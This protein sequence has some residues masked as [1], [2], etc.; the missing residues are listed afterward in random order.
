MVMMSG[1]ASSI[2]VGIGLILGGCAGDDPMSM[3]SGETEGTGG[4]TEA[5]T[6]TGSAQESGP[7]SSGGEPTPAATSDSSGEPSD[8]ST[9]P[10]ETTGQACVPGQTMADEVVMIG[11]SYL[12]ITT[13]PAELF[14]HARA[15]GAL[16]EDEVW[17]RYDQGGTQMSNGQIP[18]QFDDALAEDPVISTVVMTGGG[19]DVLL[20]SANG[21]LQNPP[22]DDPDCVA[23]LEAVF[24]AA[25]ALLADMADAGVERV[26]YF[27]YPHL[28]DGGFVQGAKNE[29]LDYAYP[30]VEEICASAP[31][32]CVF[33]DTRPG[34]E[35]HQ[36]EYFIF[37]GVHPNDA[38]SAVIAQAVW[39]AMVDNCIAQ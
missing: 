17:R 12:A 38:G 21:C 8:E 7:A 4:E 10:D 25:E 18:G 15:A 29:T 23:A 32:D 14:A 20:G 26:V 30:L 24:V 33:V 2:V 27:F 39:D 35:G 6:Q 3:S 16:A 1:R 28:P 13:V 36:D 19:N 22:P 9:G 5:G 11:D 31:L 37:D 34:F